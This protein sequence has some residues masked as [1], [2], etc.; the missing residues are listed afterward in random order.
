MRPRCRTVD[1]CREAGVSRPRPP[2]PPPPCTWPPAPSPASRALPG[3]TGRAPL[4]WLLAGA[5]KTRPWALAPSS[6]CPVQ[7]LGQDPDIPPVQV[8]CVQQGDL[9]RKMSRG[10]TSETMRRAAQN[11]PSCSGRGQGATRTLPCGPRLFCGAPNQGYRG[12]ATEPMLDL[13]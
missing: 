6:V 7:R 9:T 12:P 2:C 1:Y 8:P 10:R 3:A 4:A 11:R 13:V 5:G